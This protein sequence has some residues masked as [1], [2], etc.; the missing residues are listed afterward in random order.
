MLFIVCWSIEPQI[1]LKVIFQKNEEDNKLI[2]EYIIKSL[3][4][5]KIMFNK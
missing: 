3:D 1:I 2:D 5:E 4:E